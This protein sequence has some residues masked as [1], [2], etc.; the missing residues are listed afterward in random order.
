M[1]INLLSVEIE[2]FLTEFK[3]RDLLVSTFM[4]QMAL[5]KVA[6]VMKFIIYQH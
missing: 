2:A 5:I 4:V 1:K 6:N 3:N